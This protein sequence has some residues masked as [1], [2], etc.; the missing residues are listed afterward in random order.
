MSEQESITS[1]IKE[2]QENQP[3]KTSTGPA[4]TAAEADSLPQTESPAR[5]PRRHRNLPPLLHQ[6]RLKHLLRHPR[7][8]LVKKPRK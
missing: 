2:T 3:D 6:P 5:N 1:E 8:K 4:Q 7:P